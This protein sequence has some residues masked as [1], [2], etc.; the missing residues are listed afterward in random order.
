MSGL[1]LNSDEF[2]CLLTLLA[3]VVLC[4]GKVLPEEV[5]AFS[6]QSNLLAKKFAND[7]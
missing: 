3:F 1:N 6:K 4:N 2:N 7:I 5:E